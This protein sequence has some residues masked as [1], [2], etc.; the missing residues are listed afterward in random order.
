MDFF[1]I[2]HTLNQRMLRTV[3][4]ALF[5][6]APCLGMAQS[7]TAFRIHCGPDFQVEQKRFMET[8]K[9]VDAEAVSSFGEEEIKVRFSG[10]RSETE[11]RA[12]LEQVNMTHCQ[13]RPL[14]LAPH[15]SDA[16]TTTEGTIGDGP[17][18]RRTLINEQ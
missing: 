11:F 13:S 12:F 5:L 2:G 4:P 10:P 15:R 16:T 6:V 8:L 1:Y 9:R 3:I 17:D 7:N 14:H 18:Q